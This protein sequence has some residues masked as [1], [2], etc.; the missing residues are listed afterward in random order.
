MPAWRHLRGAF[1]WARKNEP[2]HMNRLIS[3]FCLSLALNACS[4]SSSVPDEPLQD[5]HWRVVEI[6]GQP[7]RPG[8]QAAEPHIV[9]SQDLRAHGSDGCNR[10]NTSYES[11]AGLHF[12]RMAS[13]MMACAPEVDLVA[14]EFSGA[15]A[16]TA[17][18]RIQGR[19]MELI[20]AE[21]RVRLRLE[22]TSLK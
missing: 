22:A 1:F 16:A 8:S 7:V 15:L 10:F 17:N 20:D 5:R 18:Y 14:R 3:V 19:Q 6:N 2:T 4:T 21:G 13:T 12:G 9:L 11:A